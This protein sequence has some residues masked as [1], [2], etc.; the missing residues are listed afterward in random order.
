MP[1]NLRRIFASILGLQF[2]SGHPEQVNPRFW[3]A[4]R[5]GRGIEECVSKSIAFLDIRKDG[6][7]KAVPIIASQKIH[8]RGNMFPM[9]E[10]SFAG[11]FS[12]FPFDL[13]N[14]NIITNRTLRAV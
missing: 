9:G 11:I 14:H 1:S 7:W 10:F 6:D 4:L 2:C 13:V 5:L 8:A 3:I 12:V